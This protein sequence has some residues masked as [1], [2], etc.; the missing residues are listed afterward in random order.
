[1]GKRSREK[2]ERRER[3]EIRP[4]KEWPESGLASVCL[5]IIRWGTYLALFTPLIISVKFFF[6]FV[7]P[8]SL[9]FMGLVQIIFFAWLILIINSPQYRPRKNPLLI[10][11][12]LFLIVLILSSVFGENL[13]YS[14]WSKPERMTG[15]LMW[16]H[17]LAFFLVT[18]STFQK[19]DSKGVASRTYGTGWLKIFSISIF[20]G[21][22]L[23]LITFFSK[24]PAMRGGATIGNDSFLGTYLLFTLFL[25]LY[26]ILTAQKEIRI[27]SVICFLII[28]LGLFLSGARA[29]QLSFLGGLVLLFFLYLTFIPKKKYLNFLGK[30]LLVSSFLISLIALF[31]IFQPDSFL[32]QKFVEVATKSRLVVWEKAWQGFLERPWLGWG[33]ENFEFVFVKYFNPCMFLPECGGE[34]WFDR[35]HNIIFDTLVTTGIFGLLTYFGIFLST[36]YLL[37][38]SYFKKIIDPVRSKSLEMTVLP[39]TGIS[40]GVEFWT[41]GIFTV[42]LI[43]YSVQ[44]LTVFDMV[45]SYLMLFLVLG[46]IVSISF[47]SEGIIDKEKPVPVSRSQWLI[48]IILVFFIFSFFKFIIQPLKT[49]YYVIAALI[50]P[51]ASEERL[52]YYKKTL[53]T[54]PLGKYQIREFFGQTTLE[55][56]QSEKVREVPAENFNKEIDFVIGELEKSIKES[57]LDFRSHLKLGQIYNVYA[58]LIDQ[59]KTSEAE[60]VLERTIELSPTN[61]QGYWALAQTRLYQGRFKEAFSLVEKALALEPN[62]FQSHR[63][64]IQIAKIMGDY[65]LAKRKAEEAIEINPDWEPELRQILVGG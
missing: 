8:K 1:M 25:A 36:F 2:K 48:I 35:A 37:W 41:A 4:K 40:N 15:L 58:V 21:V 18:S 23:S 24:D 20:V 9:Y 6:P 5:N 49:D 57:P 42:L 29:A 47:K 43:S 32:Q 22:I 51:P 54:S 52:N 3:K 7:G 26:L 64:A 59:A 65:D 17:L 39:K 14:F 63:L 62:L 19:S 60:R 10:A 12:V 46:F 56:A 53:E 55:F 13:S 61:Q 30:F 16:F 33:P 31:F 45:N 28:F 34:I 38:R 50:S 27:Y 11:L 44:N